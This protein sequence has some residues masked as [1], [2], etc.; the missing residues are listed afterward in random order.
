MKQHTD[1]NS[2]ECLLLTLCC[3]DLNDDRISDIVNLLTIV[4]DWKYFTK[5]CNDHGVAALAFNNLEKAGL[6]G[7]FPVEAEAF[8]RNAFYMSMSRNARNMRMMQECLDILNCEGIKTVFLKGMALEHIVYGNCGLRQMSDADVL[9][10][11]SVILEAY[12]RLI[13]KGFTPLPVKSVFHRPIIAY[14]GKHLPSLIKDGFSIELHHEL[15]SRENHYLTEILLSTA[16]EVNISG[17][18]AWLPEPQILFLY[19]VW[20]LHKHEVSNDSQ[21]RLYT[22][23]VVMIG[24][25]GNEI[26]NNRLVEL[27]GKSGMNEILATKLWC[28]RE[29]WETEMPGWLMEYTEK[30]RDTTFSEKFIFFLGSP[31][32]N[33][34][35]AGSGSYREKFAEIQGFHRKVLYLLGDL[36]PTLSFMKK[37][38]KCDSAL[39]A[40]LY[41]PHR[42]GK[43]AWLLGR[44]TGG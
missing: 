2:E 8:L 16:R 24:K 30:W 10:D 9:V 26:V 31:K 32:E 7:K 5:L 39:K 21:L 4:S 29:Y 35:T 44:K 33:P 15:F 11:H 20:H 22:D 14:Y 40:I 19:L 6:L 38:Y 43:L 3:L 12:N 13:R 28:L 34:V 37:R 41:Y 42:W 36:F 23:L 1:I 17:R 18:K 25:Y 27:A